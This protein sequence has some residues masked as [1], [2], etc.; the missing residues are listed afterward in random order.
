MIINSRIVLAFV[1][2]ALAAS[3]IVYVA[4]KP[5]VPPMHAA[6][7]VPATPAPAPPVAGAAS[8]PATAAGPETPKPATE[9]RHVARAPQYAAKPP[10]QVAAA[11]PP[12]DD[13]VPASVRTDQPAPAPQVAEPAVPAPA[14]EPAQA[15]EAVN[16]AQPP[17]PAPPPEPNRVTLPAGA[18]ITVRLAEALSS[19]KNEKGDMFFATLDQPLVADGFV[20]A[21]RGARVEGRVVNAARGRGGAIADLSLALTKVHTSD[22]QQVAVETAAYDKK[23]EASAGESAAKVGGGAVLGAIIGAAVG[24]GKGAGIGAAAGGL[25]GAG[26]AVATRGHTVT[27]PTETRLSFKLQQAVT[28][29][30][31][32]H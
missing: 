4:L 20:I 30:E 17:A 29:T 10:V 24:G 14:P 11:A 6:A 21:E 19:D 28:I 16:E 31:R 25:A 22:G 15:A 2:G 13:D 23:G 27:L 26:G 9:A 8:A 5:S 12:A 18:V 32:P 7:E 3:G 1:A